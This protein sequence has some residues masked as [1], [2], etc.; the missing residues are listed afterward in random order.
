[1]VLSL[2]AE[3]VRAA[4]VGGVAVSVRAAPRTTKDLD[5]AVV[6]GGDE[7]AEDL[8]FR[9]QRR[10]FELYDVLDQAAVGRLATGRFRLPLPGGVACVDLLFASSGIEAEIV[11]AAEGLE[12]LPGILVPVAQRGHLVALKL[13]SHDADRRP[14]DRQDLLALLARSSDEDVLLARESAALITARGFHRDRDLA[15][16]L[17]AF[18]RIVR[19]LQTGEGT[20]GCGEVSW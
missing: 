11:E 2:E 9:L 20:R 19:D 17:E 12:I 1:M 16:D 5:F 18:R 4:L 7:E 13:L 8:V 15:A 14:Q 3:E 10:G 6:V